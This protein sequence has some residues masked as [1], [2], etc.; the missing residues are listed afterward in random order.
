MKLISEIFPDL[1]NEAVSRTWNICDEVVASVAGV[2][3]W[4][5]S[6]Q[7]GLRG[8]LGRNTGRLKR[9]EVT[10]IERKAR[11]PPRDDVGRVG[12]VPDWSERINVKVYERIRRDSGRE[13]H[14]AEEGSQ[15]RER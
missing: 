6:S 13:C 7:C 1:S 4:R 11:I 9:E 2:P 3:V 15:S 8:T 10:Y 12:P 5:S 14:V